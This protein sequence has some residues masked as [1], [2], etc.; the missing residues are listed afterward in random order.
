VFRS[1]YFRAFHAAILPLLLAR[2]SLELCWLEVRGVPA[3]A[4]YNI[5]WNNKVYF[6]Q[7]GRNPALPP[8][9]RPGIVLLAHS[10]R[11]AIA[12]GRR[13]FDFLGG[14]SQYKGQF[15]PA[16]RPLVQVRVVRPGLREAGRRLLE[17]AAACGR[18]IKRGLR[19]AAD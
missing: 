19:R 3:A 13:E 7:C 18:A 15:A 5:H 4:L 8:R 1:P 11:A 17:T 16:T 12:A 2:G 6:Y 14:G 9:V 10:I